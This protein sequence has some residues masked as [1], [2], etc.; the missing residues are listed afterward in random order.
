MA[1]IVG[2][3]VM[4]LTD[5][6]EYAGEYKPRVINQQVAF[7]SSVVDGTS[8]VSAWNEAWDGVLGKDQARPE[9][10]AAFTKA[11][12]GLVVQDKADMTLDEAIDAGFISKAQMEDFLMTL[13]RRR[14]PIVMDRRSDILKNIGITLDANRNLKDIKLIDKN[15]I[16]TVAS[17]AER[18]AI[19]ADIMSNREL[20]ESF[21]SASSERQKKDKAVKKADEAAKKAAETRAARAAKRKEAT[22]QLAQQQRELAKVLEDF[23]ERFNP[24]GTEKV[25]TDNETAEDL[26]RRIEQLD[27]QISQ[28]EKEEG[29]SE[30]VW[31][32]IRERAERI[33]REQPGQSDQENFEQAAGWIGAKLKVLRGAAELQSAITVTQA[34]KKRTTLKPERIRN[35]VQEAM[36][37]K[38]L[39]N[40]DIA[41]YVNAKMTGDEVAPS[42]GTI[43]RY[44]AIIRKERAEAGPKTEIEVAGQEVDTIGQM[45]KR[46]EGHRASLVGF[47]SNPK[48]LQV[49]INNRNNLFQVIQFNAEN[50]DKVRN[51]IADIRRKLDSL[52]DMPADSALQ[53]EKQKLG[54]RL[55]FLEKQNNSLEEEY[56]A[57][58]AQIEA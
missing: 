22:D 58:N 31:Q 15:S 7:R 43:G 46:I 23:K 28:T 1:L 41:G 33:A 35:L 27:Q 57:L 13:T 24:E 8:A 16:I 42:E 37:K 36:D 9:L 29:R 48:L 6:P 52:E 5:R 14:S 54:D 40:K 45:I 49:M 51:L 50:I 21:D 17:E 11:E 10:P 4:K 34:A 44:A 56:A 12:H 32:M 39:T 18:A 53:K 55:S 25:F 19:V 38:N 20:M 30:E 3:K 47:L 2:D 26:L